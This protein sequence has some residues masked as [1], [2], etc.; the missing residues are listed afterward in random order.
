MKDG[1]FYE[2]EFRNG[3]IIGKGYRYDK[4]RET[5]YTGDFSEGEYHGKGIL[6]CKNKFVY[7][8]DFYENM[9]HGY[10]E[11]NEFKTNQSYKGQWYYNKR[12]GQGMQRYPDG[13][14]YTG[15][16]PNLVQNHKKIGNK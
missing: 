12:H 4:T 2:G 16:N 5:E 10:G 9:K 11:L 1:S 3:E 8:G 14:Q 7:E 6:R 13:S 15:K